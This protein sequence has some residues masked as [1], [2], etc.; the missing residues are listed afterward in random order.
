MTR[1]GV[2]V[3]CALVLALAGCGG[4]KKQAATTTVASTPAAQRAEVARVWQTFFAGSTSASD[5]EA[6]LEN[7]HAY[8]KAIEAQASSPLAK[9]SG[10]E[11]TRVVLTGPASASV[12]YTI[13]LGG[14]PA[15]PGQNGKAVKVDGAWKVGQA[16]F[17]KLLSL[18][19]SVPKACS[20]AG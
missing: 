2:T 11:V 3:A 5:K 9:S 4:G 7:G 18:Q 12:R 15:L 19:G 16:S 6:L 17:C 13:T 8:A 1:C 20:S 14:K 10:A